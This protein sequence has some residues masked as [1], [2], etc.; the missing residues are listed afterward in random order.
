[1]TSVSPA[2][3]SVAAALVAAG[4][5]R[6]GALTTGGAVAAAAV[7]TAALLAGLSWAL[8]LLF[9]FVSSTA[10]SRLEQP[11][12]GVRS[13]LRDGPRNAKQVLANG[14]IFAVAA[15]GYIV[16]DGS[17]WTAI[18]AGAMAAAT[19]DTWST[20][21]G[22]RCGGTPRHILRLTRL[23]KGASGGIT[24]VGSAA[25]VVGAWLTSA[26]ARGLQFDVAATAIVA[27]GLT[28]AFADSVLGA[29]VQE[30]RWCDTCGV[31]TERP[32]HT[33]GASTRVSGGWRR[34]DND[35]VNLTSIGIG[36]LVTCLLS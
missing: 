27:G 18:G 23:P 20:E 25:A 1:M 12:D 35:A 36:A 5:W 6:L 8:L 13:M 7:G 30:R 15:L 17:L 22:T 3:A 19:A 11:G 29:T 28:G 9:F 16:Q 2:L 34:F 14:A 24:L 32:V 26:V 31:S 10:L 33:C 21:V 4:A